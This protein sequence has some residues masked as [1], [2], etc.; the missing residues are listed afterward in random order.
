MITQNCLGRAKTLRII[1]II[2]IIIGYVSIAFLPFHISWC[3]RILCS[4]L[5][6][7]L[8]AKSK[9]FGSLWAILCYILILDIVI[10]IVIALAKEKQRSAHFTS[11]P[12]GLTL[13]ISGALLIGLGFHKTISRNPEFWDH[14][15]GYIFIFYSLIGFPLFLKGFDSLFMKWFSNQICEEQI[16]Q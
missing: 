3:M 1:A 7:G 9:G 2:L 15:Q 14:G 16:F 13:L 10:F 6:I 4:G 5:A 12:L 8:Y 11:F